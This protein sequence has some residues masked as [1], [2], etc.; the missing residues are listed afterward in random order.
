MAQIVVIGTVLLIVSC[1]NLVISIQALSNWSCVSNM[2]S[3]S[4]QSSFAFNVFVNCAQSTSL[5]LY[6][7]LEGTARA[8]SVINAKIQGKQD[9]DACYEYTICILSQ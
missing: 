2:A 7:I 5:K 6:S 8:E 3:G 9:A 1:N 4:S